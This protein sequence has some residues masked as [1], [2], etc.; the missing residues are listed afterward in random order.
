[1]KEQDA[2]FYQEI[3]KLAADTPPLSK[4]EAEHLRAL[5]LQRAEQKKKKQKKPV[6]LKW[7]AAA[8]VL[9][10]VAAGGFVLQRPGIPA[11]PI[12]P[13]PRIRETP[14]MFSM[15]PQEVDLAAAAALF[16]TDGGEV[17]LT[18]SPRLSLSGVDFEN[19]S[20]RLLLKGESGLQ[21]SLTGEKI[22]TVQAEETPN[23]EEDGISGYLVT[24]TGA[25]TV[26]AL[27]GCRLQ[28]G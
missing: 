23:P 13:E 28:I 6:W 9:V 15:E 26:E 5:T 1:M 4:K 17:P 8:A 24:I 11:E 25:E 16:G 19:G 20:C 21:L 10:L 22:G 12:S 3:G 14:A 2:R 18:E 7:T 27:F